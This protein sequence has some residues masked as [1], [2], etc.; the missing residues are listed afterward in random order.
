MLTF[1]IMII[2]IFTALGPSGESADQPYNDPYPTPSAPADPTTE[3]PEPDPEPPETEPT[4]STPPKK[5]KPP[6]LRKQEGYEVIPLPDRPSSIKEAAQLIKNNTAYGQQ[7]SS[8]ACDGLPSDEARY[9][10]GSVSNETWRKVAQTA[11][12][13]ARD[14]WAKPL[15]EAGYQATH[16]KV[17][18]FSG[19]VDSPC[20][21]AD[22]PG[23][24]CSA[25]Q[26]IYLNKDGGG[27][28]HPSEYQWTWYLMTMMH[29]YGHHAQARTGL[30][31]ASWM[32]QQSQESEDSY[33]RVNRRME[34]QANCFGGMG[35]RRTAA[36]SRGNFEIYASRMFGEEVHGSTKNQY[37]WYTQGWSNTKVSRCN[38]YT[39]AGKD[40][41]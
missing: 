34:L 27:G 19:A 24:Y 11:A 1:V 8:T 14:M 31:T 17:T 9:P 40:V 3:P 5:E 22:A 26:A 6:H 15:A 10:Y 39:A 41:N 29:E 13:C 4:E 28:D 25:N 38:T 18:I 2:G 35:L 7:V 32:W 21:E 20:G 33:W 16:A 37:R 36:V 12:N 23:F 30:L